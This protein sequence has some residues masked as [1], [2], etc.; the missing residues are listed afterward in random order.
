MSINMAIATTLE[1]RLIELGG[2]AA[3]RVR[4]DPAPGHATLADLMAVNESK[5][6]GLFELVDGTLVEKA[7]SYEASI[8]A[9]A[10]ARI[11]GTFVFKNRLGLTSG[12]DGFFRLQTST[13]GPDVAF[14]ARE[15]L[16][17]GTFPSQV[18][19]Q[20]VP[21][22]VVEVLS[23][24]NTK[25]EMARKRL[26]YFHCGVQVVWMVDCTHRTVAIYTSPSEWCVVKEHE[27]IDGGDA[28]PGFTS[29]VGDFFADLDIGQPTV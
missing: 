16:P 19:P 21:N 13:R 12:A 3:M 9:I 22:L 25:A 17:G 24:G 18:Y 29:C 20:I 15:K 1:D 10:I 4:L 23:P 7:M 11:I 27:M 28:I 26:E 14:V 5:E 8:V 2:I 6:H